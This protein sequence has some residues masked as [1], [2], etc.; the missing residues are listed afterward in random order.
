M[1]ASQPVTFLPMLLSDSL[2]YSHPDSVEESK[3]VARACNGDTT[4][5]QWILDHHRHA[6]YRLAVVVLRNRDDAEDAAQDTFVSAFRSIKGYRKSGSLRAWLA[7]IATRRCL[8][9]IK[10]K[11]SRREDSITFHELRSHNE[12]LQTLMLNALF[13]EITPVVR[14]A[15]VLHEIEGYEYQEVA[16]ILQIPVGTVRSRIHAARQQFRQL[17]LESEGQ[18]SDAT[19]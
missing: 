18:K 7:Q 1:H 19:E 2:A 3:V 5:F 4:A 14:A 12:A 16:G 15:L 8:D 17:W 13:D 6:I 10:F 11:E 9:K